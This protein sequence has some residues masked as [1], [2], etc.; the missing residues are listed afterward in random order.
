[1][2]FFEDEVAEAIREAGLR[3]VLGQGIVEVGSP[4]A[5]VERKVADTQRFV[6]RWRGHERIVPAVA[7]HAP[8]TVSPDLF[9]RLHALA[10]PVIERCNNRTRERRWWRQNGGCH[11]AISLPSAFGPARG[12]ST[13]WFV[14]W[15]LVSLRLLVDRRVVSSLGRRRI[16]WRARTAGRKNCIVGNI[17]S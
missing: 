16:I 17:V 5:D 3:A 11:G 2:Y 10:H 9:R 7:P 8:Y 4:A 1:M 12:Q 14:G 13:R 6:E 15:C